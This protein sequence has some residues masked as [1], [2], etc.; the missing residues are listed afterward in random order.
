MVHD[1]PPTASHLS[2]NYRAAVQR[3]AETRHRAKLAL[4]LRRGPRER[5]FDREEAGDRLSAVAPVGHRPGD[6]DLVA[7]V[8]KDLASVIVDR[9]RGK[10][11][12]FAEKAMDRVGADSP[13]ERRRAGDVDEQEESLL[14]ARAVVASEHDVA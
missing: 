5:L 12:D 6:H 10:S 3:S 9:V 1:R 7:D 8:L 11:E 4:E 2:R 13:G 14:R